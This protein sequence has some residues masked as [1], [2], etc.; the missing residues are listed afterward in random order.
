MNIVVCIKQVPD[1]N[2]FAD[3]IVD[4][5]SG[6]INREGIPTVIN[7]VDRNAIEAGL[8][9]A[10]RYPGK[11]SILTMG[12]PQAKQALE[13]ALAMGGDEAILLSDRAFA[14]SDSLATARTLAA[15]ITIFLPF[16][17]ILCGNE[18]IDSG[19][20]QVGPQLAELLD[21]PHISNARA[22]NFIDGKTLQA[23]R[24]LGSNIAQIRL[25]LPSLVTVNGHINQ[26][27]FITVAGIMGV[28]GKSIKTYGLADL[29]LAPEQAGLAG[30]PTRLACLS[31]SK[32]QR[33]GELLKGEPDQVALEAVARI[34]KALSS[35]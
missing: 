34:Q 30:S 33:H 35:G 13:E 17:L 25:N 24:Y 6:V 28:T 26:P 23:E 20:S 10:E 4:P 29:K 3:I 16:D 27:R 21:I 11:V 9:I 12:P 15:A 22:I 31:R 7:P 32:W 1:P 14:G 19:T 5:L 18:T 2:R 8:Q